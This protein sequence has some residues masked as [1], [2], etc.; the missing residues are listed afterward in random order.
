MFCLTRPRD[1]YIRCHLIRAKRPGKKKSVALFR[2]EYLG[3]SCARNDQCQIV[4][5]TSYLH[6]LFDSE[7]ASRE[8]TCGSAGVSGGPGLFT[9]LD[10]K[11]IPVL[12]D[13]CTCVYRSTAVQHLPS[14]R[15]ESR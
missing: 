3:T 13:P 10:D 11:A 14:W 5:G 6:Y 1:C 12:G 9:P 4:L 2:A 8:C 7:V 15:Q